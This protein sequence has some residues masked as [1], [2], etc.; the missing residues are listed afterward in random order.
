MVMAMDKIDKKENKSAGANDR[1]TARMSR[2]MIKEQLQNQ[3]VEKRGFFKRGFDYLSGVNYTGYLMQ[4]QTKK[5]AKDSKALQRLSR[6]PRKSYQSQK[7]SGDITPK[8]SV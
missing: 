1:K 4:R 7:V 2:L 8:S 5:L 6:H 3:Q